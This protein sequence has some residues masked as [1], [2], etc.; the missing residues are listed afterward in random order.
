[1]LLLLFSSLASIAAITDIVSCKMF[2]V[3]SAKAPGVAGKRLRE[4]LVD[5][6]T[7]DVGLVVAEEEDKEV[8]PEFEAV[9]A[10][11]VAAAIVAH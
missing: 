11:V 6:D 1:M 4:R 5:E 9:A 10:A 2:S 8:E 7:G 3:G